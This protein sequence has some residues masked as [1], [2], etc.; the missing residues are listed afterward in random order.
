[1]LSFSKEATTDAVRRSE[2]DAET[3]RFSGFR[4]AFDLPTYKNASSSGLR[5]S[6]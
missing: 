2:S 3:F 6:A 4:F 5:T 1:M